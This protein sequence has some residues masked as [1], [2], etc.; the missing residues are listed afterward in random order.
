VKIAETVNL[1]L[2]PVES[3]MLDIVRAYVRRMCASIRC[4]FYVRGEGVSWLT[5]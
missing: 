2:K 5:L 3:V 4:V 1:M